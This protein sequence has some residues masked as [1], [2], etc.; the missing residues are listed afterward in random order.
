MA[1]AVNGEYLDDDSIRQEAASIRQLLLQEMPEEDT[2]TIDLKA[3]EWAAENAIERVLLRQAAQGYEDLDKNS[4]RP[5]ENVR[6][7][8][9]L[10]QVTAEVP[11]PKRKE[12]VEF[13]QQNQKNFFTPEA[14]RASH[15]VKNVD[16]QTTEAE[17][18]EIMEKAQA[19]LRHGR[20]FHDVAAEY[21]DCPGSGELGWF[22]RGEMVQ[23]F[24]VVVFSLK[25]GEVSGIFRSV[26]GFHLATVQERRQE[27]I[28]PLRDVYED[29]EQLILNSRK[30]EC[31]ERFLDRLRSQAE[32]RRVPSQETKTRA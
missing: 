3:R 13:Y 10:A 4:H 11:L 5:D 32:I 30:K 15:I 1:L 20:P 23:E 27:A 9:L 17:A 7:E 12:V 24:D 19:E 14:V 21:S 6:I 2:L 16:E 25:P 8:K 29:V 28:R 22:S 26:F 31:V 18:Y